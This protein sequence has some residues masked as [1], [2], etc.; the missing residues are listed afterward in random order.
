MSKKKYKLTGFARFFIV[1]LILVPIAYFAA[2]YINEG[3]G[4][5]DSLFDKGNSSSEKTEIVST[6]RSKSAL[7]KENQ[8]LKDSIRT[9]NLEYQELK[10]QYKLLEKETG[11]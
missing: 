9:L 5:I 2:L 3:Q 6:P 7:E 10:R 11:N 8:V 1:M 4:G